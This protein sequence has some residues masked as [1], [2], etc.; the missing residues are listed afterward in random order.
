MTTHRVSVE[1]F[2]I[3][4][5]HWRSYLSKIK[6]GTPKHDEVKARLQKLENYRLAE[7]GAE[8]DESWKGHG[9]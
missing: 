4:I 9:G 7:F 1:D 6:P 2:D 5:G 8:Q 3:L